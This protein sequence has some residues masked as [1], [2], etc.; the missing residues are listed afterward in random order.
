MPHR[1]KQSSISFTRGVI[2]T[3]HGDFPAQYSYREL[4]G[5]GR[6]QLEFVLPNLQIQLQPPASAE[7]PQQFGT[8]TS[9]HMQ[10][11]QGQVIDHIL[12]RHQLL[13]LELRAVSNH[14]DDGSADYVQYPGCTTFLLDPHQD[15][16]SERV[17][18]DAKRF[19]GS[20]SSN[21][22]S[23][24]EQ[25]DFWLALTNHYLGA[26]WRLCTI[27]VLTNADSGHSS[28]GFTYLP[29]NQRSPFTTVMIRNEDGNRVENL[30]CSEMVFRGGG[31]WQHN[32]AMS[33]QSSVVE[34]SSIP[35]PLS[36]DATPGS[37]ALSTPSPSTV[38]MDSPPQYMLPPEQW[39]E[40]PNDEPDAQ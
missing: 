22:Q 8:N 29:P 7:N 34:A 14:V 5:Y 4:S 32:Q 1:H 6:G 3:S 38:G 37:M 16:G 19:L 31:I 23:S 27:E 24:N 9:D 20:Q 13:P 21:E 12:S 39:G 26:E 35:P 30:P 36:I 10:L 28:L 18:E 11:R 2:T 40:I 33:D 17:L 15:E 25:D